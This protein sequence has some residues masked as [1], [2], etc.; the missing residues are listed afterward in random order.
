VDWAESLFV[1][2]AMTYAKVLESQWK[3]GE[4]HAKLLSTLFEGSR[5]KR[6]GVLDIP[7]GIGRVSVPLAR[8]GYSV[9]GVDM[10]PYFVRIARRKARRFGVARK[11]SFAVGLMNSVGSMFPKGSFDAAINIFTSIGYGTESDDLA[12]FA[13][14]RRV[15]RTGG[16]FVIGRLAN[17]DYIFSHF[18]RNLYDE[19]DDLLVLHENELDEIHSREKSRWRFYRKSGKTLRYVGENRIDLR[20]YSPH[21]LAT[22]LGQAG[23]KVSS[24]YDSLSYRRPFSSDSPGMTIVAEAL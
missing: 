3:N 24:V 17:R 16:L 22:L 6:C 7:C 1:G 13:S 14:L 23:W 18:A 2:N 12:F 20:L 5:L 4:E 15:V 11:T 21:E 9:T 8:L 10:S 19:T